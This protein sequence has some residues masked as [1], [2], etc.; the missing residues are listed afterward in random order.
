MDKMIPKA[1]ENMGYRKVKDGIYAKPVGFCLLTARTDYDTNEVT[2]CVK[3][4]NS[5]EEVVY[6]SHTFNADLDGTP[7]YDKTFNECVVLVA[8]NEYELLSDMPRGYKTYDFYTFSLKQE[9]A[10][11]LIDKL[12]E[13]VK[14]LGRKRPTLL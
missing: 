6:S 9:P 12:F 4:N 14:M 5:R 1:L 8:E 10:K 11:S 3:F 13:E 7:D 2:M